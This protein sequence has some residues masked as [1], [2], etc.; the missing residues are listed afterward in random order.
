MK[1]D[2]KK[3]SGFQFLAFVIPAVVILAGIILWSQRSDRASVQRLLGGND[4]RTPAQQTDQSPLADGRTP[5]PWEFDESKNR[6]WDANHRHWHPGAPPPE[7]RRTAGPPE[8]APQASNPNVP[9]PEPWQYDAESNQHFDPGHRHW[10]PGPPPPED[11]RTE[12]L[13]LTPAPGTPPIPGPRPG[14]P[15]TAGP[16]GIENPEPY[17][18]DAVSNTHYDPEHDHWHQGPPPPDKAGAPGA[19]GGSEESG[20]SGDQP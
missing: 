4:T 20:E 1:H 15:P 5:S 10:H 3:K 9:D 19:S 8:G 12:S 2:H 7:D 14:Q 13:G 6:H 11:Q 17:Q 18:Y 16:P